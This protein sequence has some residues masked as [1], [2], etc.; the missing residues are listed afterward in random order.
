MIAEVKAVFFDSGGTLT[1]PTGGT[2]WP[3]P[4]FG[5]MLEG[6]GFSSPDREA[7]EAALAEGPEYLVN[8]P[9]PDLESELATYAAFYRIVLGRLF[10]SALQSSWVGRRRLRYT[11][12][13]SSPIRM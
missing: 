9:A 8:H 7:T 2:W 10:G 12:S 5:E 11:I 6:A 13:T 1:H 3:K 4:R